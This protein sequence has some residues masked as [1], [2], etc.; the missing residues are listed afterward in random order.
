M[1]NFVQGILKQDQLSL[2]QREKSRSCLSSTASTLQAF[3][4]EEEDEVFDAGGVAPLV[5]VPGDDLAGL[6]DGFGELGVDDGGEGVAAEVGRD[7]LFFGVAEDALE[8]AFGGGLEGG[9]D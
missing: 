1:K 2:L 5:V 6:A 8:G 9:V 4:D 3:F 7:E